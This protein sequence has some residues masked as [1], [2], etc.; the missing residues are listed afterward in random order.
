VTG[1]DQIRPLVQRQLAGRAP[2]LQN[3]NPDQGKSDDNIQSGRINNITAISPSI[4]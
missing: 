3:L 4:F 2:P 1:A